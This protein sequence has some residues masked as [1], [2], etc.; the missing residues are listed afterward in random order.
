M[1][2]RKTESLSE[3]AYNYIKNNILNLTYLPG[4]ILTESGL[5]AELNISRM[6][7]RTA[8]IALENEGLLTSEHYKS[9]KVKEITR[10]D[11]LEIYQL[12]ELLEV[13]ALKMIFDL[14]KTY[15]YSYRIEEKVVRMKAA[16]N[17]SYKWEKAD[18]EFHMEIV[19][20]YENERINRIYS[21]NQNELVRIGILSKKSKDHVEHII[22]RLYE[23]VEYVRNDSYEKALEI[24]MIDH[25]TSGKDMALKQVEKK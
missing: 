7:I 4:S 25:I 17:D 2:S 22:K 3:L 24:L 1:S 5:A 20:V 18:T 9:I 8:V 15:E 6:P 10:K 19:S 14:K 21:N 11:I 16:Q 23:F 12:R 13:N